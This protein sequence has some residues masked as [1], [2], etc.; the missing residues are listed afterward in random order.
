M[1]TARFYAACV[2]LTF[3]YMHRKKI[4]YRDLKPENLLMDKNGFLKITDFGFAKF[5]AG[6]R[7]FTLCGTPDYLAPEVVLGLG[8]GLAVDW[9]TLGILIFEML[10]S[11]PPFYDE[12]PMNT[13]S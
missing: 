12:N 3:A 6:G 1:G 8:H 9:W 13:Y 4:V 7:T 5:I 10:A 11:Y 2:T